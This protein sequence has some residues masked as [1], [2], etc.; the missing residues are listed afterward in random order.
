MALPKLETGTRHNMFLPSSGKKIQYRPFLVKEEKIILQA[1]QSEDENE[2]MTAVKN[3]AENCTFG[4]VDVDNIPFVDL[5]WIFLKLYMKSKGE[6]VEAKY[7][8]KNLV[9]DKP[10]GHVSDT[11]IDLEKVVVSEKE[12]CDIVLQKNGPIGMVLKYPTK[13]FAEKWKDQSN[14]PMVIFDMLIDSI[15]SIYHGESVFY[16]EDLDISEIRDFVDDFDDEQFKKVND[17]FM[18]I[19]KLQYEFDFVCSKCGFQKHVKLEGL[20]S[21]LG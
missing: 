19:P 10:C 8:C 15:E 12:N 1:I 14:D 13:A 11:V 7:K 21:F 5:E 9:D 17:F 6:I 2:L 3:V 16:S 20:K 18:N 4:D